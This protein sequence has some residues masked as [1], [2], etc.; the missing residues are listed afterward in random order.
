MVSNSDQSTASIN[1]APAP[2]AKAKA[3]HAFPAAAGGLHPLP[4]QVV[5]VVVMLLIV[6]EPL[7]LEL[8]IFRELAEQAMVQPPHC[9]GSSPHLV[10]H[11]SSRQS[12][13]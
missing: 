11:L 9:A 4:V 7:E 8:Q 2:T 12:G 5:S 1:E 13:N 6:V 3:T 10:T